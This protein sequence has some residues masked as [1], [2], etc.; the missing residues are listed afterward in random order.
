MYV[1]SARTDSS[2]YL[3]DYLSKVYIRTEVSELCQKKISSRLC[4]IIK[5]SHIQPNS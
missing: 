5:N 4:I 1:L 2:V 3:F